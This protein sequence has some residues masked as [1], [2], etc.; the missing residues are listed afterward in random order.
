M[1]LGGSIHYATPELRKLRLS[2]SDFAPT[3]DD[4]WV[5]RNTS[6]A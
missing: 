5:T 2:A 6:W 4:F 3:G 1:I